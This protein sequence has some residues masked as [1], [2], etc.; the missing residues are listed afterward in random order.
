[1][2]RVSVRDEH[3]IDLRN[4]DPHLCQPL[5]ARLARINEKT[6]LTKLDKARGTKPSAHRRAWSRAEKEQ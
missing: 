3:C 1:M 6:D 2:I 4:I 5:A